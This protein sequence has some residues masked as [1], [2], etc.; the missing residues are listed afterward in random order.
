MISSNGRASNRL[1]VGRGTDAGS[2]GRAPHIRSWRGVSRRVRLFAGLG[3]AAL[4]LAA[5]ASLLALPTQAQTSTVTFVS[6]TTLN[7]AIGFNSSIK[8]AQAF[9]TGSSPVVISEVGIYVSVGTGKTTTVKIRE[10][11]SSDKPGDLVDT[12]T[13]PL[14][15]TDDAVNTFT[16]PSNLRLMANTTYWISVNEGIHLL[17]S[18]DLETTSGNAQ[19]GEPNWQI[20]NGS[21]VR[22]AD[23]TSWTSSSSHSLLIE[24]RGT[25]PS[26]DATLSDLELEDARNGSAI[27]LSPGFSS[28]H[29]DYSAS[30]GFP[31]PEITVIPTTNDAGASIKYLNDSNNELSDVIGGPVRLPGQPGGRLAERDQG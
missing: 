23:T 9:T 18:V 10:N 13:N 17:N 3:L 16:A 25:Y 28:G 4:L 12:L 15:F 21:L 31:V 14:T 24:I 7:I 5:V 11:N 2:G 29:R 19:T 26:S 30:V 27:A 6:N 22:T 20:A 8:N 1:G